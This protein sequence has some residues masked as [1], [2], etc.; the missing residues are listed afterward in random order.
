MATLCPHDGRIRSAY[1]CAECRAAHELRKLA[2]WL[3]SRYGRNH[4]PMHTI[5]EEAERRARKL[6][7]ERKP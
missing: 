5:I 1:T 4:Y 3:I 2:R 7:E 6:T